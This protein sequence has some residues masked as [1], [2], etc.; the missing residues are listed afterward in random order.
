MPGDRGSSRR[1]EGSRT[2]PRGPQAGEWVR[3]MFRMA[4][5]LPIVAADMPAL[6]M[7]LSTRF[8]VG[9]DAGVVAADRRTMRIASPDT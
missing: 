3:H 9:P 1:I 5:G 7:I 4:S 2:W 6:C 8:A